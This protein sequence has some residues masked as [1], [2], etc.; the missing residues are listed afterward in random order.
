[1]VELL[2]VIAIIAILIGLLFPA[3][4]AVRNAARSTQCKSNLR[5]FGLG[6]LTRSSN[7]PDG[8]YCT[9][10]FDPD[11]D[12]SVEL[13]GWVADCVDQEIQPA[14]LL[15]PSSICQTSEKISSYMGGSSSSSK[16]PEAR[17]G[18]GLRGQFP[19]TPGAVMTGQQ[20]SDLLFAGGWNTNYA[21]SWFLARSAPLF[22][23]STGYAI[24][25]M[26][27][28]YRGNV[29]A[30]IQH[31]VGPLR[32]SQ[33]DK[34]NKPASSIALM[35]CG[36]RG[37]TSGGA[38]D[39]ALNGSIP[40]P[41]N[42]PAGAPASETMNDGPSISVIA[43]NKVVTAGN[44]DDPNA[45]ALTRAVLSVFTEITKGE[46]GTDVEYR[47][48]TRDM[49]AYHSKSLNVLF[50]D[51]SVRAFQDDNG[52]GFI[53]PG[54]AV[55]NTNATFALTGYTSSECELNPW[56]WYTGVFV[57]GQ[58]YEKEFEN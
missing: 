25:S 32:A 57:E 27:E 26:K 50:A 53:N 5:Q 49:F 15:C 51:G 46:V 47:Q 19:G 22:D 44:T 17:R 54:F 58:A 14:F 16:G 23:P 28:W 9:G 18:A 2:V 13:Y 38:G 43:S 12:G 52:D 42:I 55:D 4:I 39:G 11:R 37:D 21:S 34:G 40:A 24:T 29:G 3:F 45:S 41:W 33:M 7:A 56:E 8:S 35:G 10:A 6:L 30:V 36:S 31:T 20:V 48:D 1:M